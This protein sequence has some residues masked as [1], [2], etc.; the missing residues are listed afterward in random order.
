MRVAPVHVSNAS[1]TIELPFVSVWPLP[2]GYSHSDK[3]TGRSVDQH[4]QAQ[5]YLICTYVSVG[6]G[7]NMRPAKADF[8]NL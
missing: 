6:N 5:V 3:L 4:D 2:D 7:K 8:D 1:N